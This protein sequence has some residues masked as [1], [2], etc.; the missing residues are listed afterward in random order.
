M[1]GRP[2]LQ[3]GLH[4]RIMLAK[5]RKYWRIKDKQK[6]KLRIANVDALVEAC[7]S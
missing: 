7:R 2:V 4:V 6:R 1:P 5:C 3:I